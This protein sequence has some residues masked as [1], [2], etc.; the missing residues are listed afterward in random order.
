MRSLT[1]SLTATLCLSPAIPAGGGAPARTFICPPALLPGDTIALVAPANSTDDHDIPRL[2]ATIEGWGFRVRLA[3]NL[4]ARE[5]NLAG[6][7]ATRAREFMEAWLDPRVRMVWAITGG[8]GCTRILDRLDYGALRAHPKIFCGMSDVTALHAAIGRETG[9][10]TFLGPNAFWPLVRDDLPPCRYAETWF[11]RAIRDDLCRDPSGALLPD[12]FTYEWPSEPRDPQQLERPDVLDPPATLVP[13]V[14]RGRLVGGNLSLL[15]ALTGT[16]WEL[17]TAGRILVIEDVGEE[18][19]RLDRM[20]CQLRLAG[21][22]DHLA[23]AILGTWRKCAPE[24]P[25]HSFTVRQVLEHYF[26]Q[27]PYPVL[28]N[29]PTGHV[30]EQA[31]LPLNGLAELDATNCTVRILETPVTPRPR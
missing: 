1:L 3:G 5:G 9:L 27:A 19:Y 15:A 18:P 6:D 22:L 21:L 8:Y 24:N 30:P 4:R 11:W 25:E 14:A 31:T 2:A 12:G 16:P 20:L 23:G 7:D 29:F 26:G 13:G 10:I 28:L 17:Q